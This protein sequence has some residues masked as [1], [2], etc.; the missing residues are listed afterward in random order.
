MQKLLVA[1]TSKGKLGEIKDILGDLPLKLLMLREV[2]LP[3]DFFVLET[4][5]T[6]AEN[7]CLKAQSYGKASGLLTLADDSGLCVDALG[8]KPG[9]FTSRYAPGSDQDRWQKLLKEL[10][11][12]PLSRRTAQ[13]VATVALYDPGSQKTVV[14][15]GRCFGHI[16]FG[17]KGKHGFGYDPVFMV[18]KLGKHFA[19]LT[20]KEKNQVSHRAVAVKKIKP[21]L[22]KLLKHET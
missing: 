18:D 21:I 2:K 3:K 6:F 17:P 22:A 7:A 13:F 5:S 14:K 8:G 12:L 16:A 1:T 20:R 4:G 15:E 11:D 19:Q 9:L 10:G